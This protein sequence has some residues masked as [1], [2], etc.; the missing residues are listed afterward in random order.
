MGTSTTTVIVRT[1]AAAAVGIGIGGTAQARNLIRFMPDL[2][3]KMVSVRNMELMEA[4]TADDIIFTRDGRIDAVHA[5][6]LI[7]LK[8]DPPAQWH[9]R[10][11][12]SDPDTLE[13]DDRDVRYTDS[14]GLPEDT[15]EVVEV[16]G[17]A[18][19]LFL[20]KWDFANRLDLGPGTY[21]INPKGVRGEEG[22]VYWASANT[23]KHFGSSAMLKSAELGVPDWTTWQKYT[24]DC[25]PVDGAMIV[26]GSGGGVPRFLESKIKKARVVEGRKVDGSKNHLYESEGLMFVGRSRT[27]GGEAPAMR[28]RITY[29]V[30]SRRHLQAVIL[31]MS[32]VMDEPGGLI[33]IRMKNW[34]TKEWDVLDLIPATT[35]LDYC[36]VARPDRPYVKKKK[37]KVKVEIDFYTSRGGNRFEAAFDQAGLR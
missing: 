36:E 8:I 15:G 35:I 17:E 9:L 20:I 32:S 37:G 4:C 19:R 27:G 23:G 12:G 21:W 16:L 30:P 34:R 26:K 5:Y 18:F 3:E 13:P 33:A 28:T 24:K 29:K 22:L 6:F 11:L 25:L 1:I 31:R 14:D 10:I 7:P 2:Q